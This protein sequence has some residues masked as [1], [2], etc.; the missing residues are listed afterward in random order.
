MIDIPF[1]ARRRGRVQNALTLIALVSLASTGCTGGWDHASYDF[2][3]R[4]AQAKNV[5]LVVFYKDHLDSS[6]G[7]TEDVLRHPRLASLMSGKVRCQLLTE[8]EPNRRFVAQY[9]VESAPALIVIHPD[10]T[11]H[12][13]EGAV[14]LEQA[15]KF[16]S[17]AIA[18]GKKPT[19]NPAVPRTY[20]YR[21]INIYEDAVEEAKRQNRKMLVLYK[22]WL[23]ADS[24]ELIRRMDKPEVARHFANM[25]HCILDWDYMPNRQHMARFSADKVPA[26]VIVNQDGSYHKLVGLASMKQIVE[27]A[28]GSRGPG[29][30]PGRDRTDRTSSYRWA[31]DFDRALSAGRRQNQNVFVFY[32]SVFSDASNQMEQLLTESG[33]AALF[34][35]TVNCKL[36]WSNP[37]NRKRMDRYGVDRVPA[38]VII[39]PDGTYHA[40]IGPQRADDF[41]RLVTDAERPGRTAA[42]R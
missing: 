7:Q 37:R 14:T 23:S 33:T 34:R 22:W 29:I 42:D 31:T 38:F 19:L 32:H 6:S 11:Y 40:R 13:R 4:D 30:R 15:E 20:E 28:V 16:L 41:R 21:W 5:D 10:E 35:N 9:G 12:V 27:F 1:P 36:D 26:L 25:V 2:A 18:P 17:E 24:S 8:F 3:Q 39:R